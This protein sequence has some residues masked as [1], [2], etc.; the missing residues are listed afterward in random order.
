MDVVP[1]IQKVG[2]N[3]DW[4]ELQRTIDREKRRMGYDKP[5][6]VQLLVYLQNFF[7]GKWGDSY[8]VEPYTPVIEI[9]GTIFPKTLNVMYIL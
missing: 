8:L 4:D 3:L 6:L 5:I 1:V 9:I 2:F 7:T